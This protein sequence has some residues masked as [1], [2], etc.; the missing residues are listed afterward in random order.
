VEVRPDS[1]S[2]PGDS[3]TANTGGAH[4]CARGR[5]RQAQNG[6]PVGPC[7]WLTELG[8]HA[9]EG[10]QRGTHTNGTAYPHCLP[11]RYTILR[12]YTHTNTSPTG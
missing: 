10:C 8:I 9:P 12:K 5:D 6:A 4:H 1:G 3:T 7:N 11:T 2:C